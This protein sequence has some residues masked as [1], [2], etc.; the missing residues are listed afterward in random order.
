MI[1]RS[2]IFILEFYPQFIE[3]LETNRNNK[4]LKFRTGIWAVVCIFT[5]DDVETLLR[6]N[7]FIDKAEYYIYLHKWLGFGLLTRFV[8]V[9]KGSIRNSRFC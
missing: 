1:L 8:N 3:S 7:R 2:Y 9:F 5:P 6:S 4:I